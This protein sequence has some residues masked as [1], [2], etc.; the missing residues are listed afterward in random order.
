MATAVLSFTG[1]RVVDV[2]PVPEEW[3]KAKEVLDR[4][5]SCWREALVISPK[6]LAA[7][8]GFL[9]KH[10]PAEVEELESRWTPRQI[11]EFYLDHE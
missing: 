8:W 2:S 3:E 11:I 1:S 5:C 7:A 4:R 6:L 9:R 10:Y